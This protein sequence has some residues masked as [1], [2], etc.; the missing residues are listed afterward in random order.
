MLASKWITIAKGIAT[1]V[2]PLEWLRRRRSRTGGTISARYCYTVWLRHLILAHQNRLVTDPQAVAELGPGDSIGAGLAA[3]LSGVRRYY[4]VDAV[5]FA[6]PSRN[7]AIFEQ[8]VELFRMKATLPGDDEFPVVWPPLDSYAFP[9]HILDERRLAAALDPKRIELIRAAL[10]EPGHSNRIITYAAPWSDSSIVPAHSIDLVFSQ[11]VLEHVDDLGTMYAATHKWLKPD[12]CCSHTID[13]QS[14]GTSD[15]WN[16]HWSYSNFVWR[17]IRGTRPYLLNR[18][19]RSV[20][21][22]LAE[23]NGFQV[24]QDVAC[25]RDDGLPR[26]RLAGRWRNCPDEDLR[27]ATTLLQLCPVRSS[28]AKLQDC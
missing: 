23:A 26:A 9:D 28:R 18:E 3:L 21:Y 24:V 20:H 6:N 7:L 27:C 2:P 10:E 17:L 8:L 5:P 19:P 15:S 16:G 13:F 14:H 12:G 1:F 4:A 25:L 11:A 22:A